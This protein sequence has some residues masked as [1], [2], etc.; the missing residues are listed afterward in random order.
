LRTV[1]H[2]S[3]LL[4]ALAYTLLNAVKP[5]TIDDTAYHAYAAHIAEKPLDP[6]GFSVYWWYQ[7]EVANEVLAPPL[8]SYWWAP[9]IRLFGDRPFLWKLWLLPVALLFAAALYDLS[10]RLAPGLELPLVAMTLFSPAF[11]PTF[12]LMLDVPALAVALASLALFCR[13]C[14]RD[15]FV[16]AAL[17]GLVAGLGIETKYTAFLAPAVMLLYALW[18]G[19][20]RLWPAA[21]LVAAQ[22]F[23]AWEFLMALLYDESHF[24]FHL[25]YNMR[26]SEENGWQWGRLLPP[27]V[28]YLGSLAWPAALLA[29]RGFGL[30]RWAL[31]PAAAAGLLAYAGVAWRGGELQ[32]SIGE[33][34]IRVVFEELLFGTLGA[35]V[36]LIAGAAAITLARPAA[37]L[38][39]WRR[40]RTAAAQGL[41]SWREVMIPSRPTRLTAFL[42]SWLALEVVGYVVLTP[43]PAARRVLGVVVV[44]FLLAG[45]LAARTSRAPGTDR[46]VWGIAACSA[47]LGL[48]VYG[49]DFVEARAQQQAVEEARREIQARGG[50]RVWYVGHWGFQYY[51]EREGMRSISAYPADKG[52]IPIPPQSALQKGDWLVLPEWRLSARGRF[53]AG[54][55]QQDYRL[56]PE[57]TQHAF[58]VVIDDPVPLQ[59]IMALYSGS[60]AVV[61]H[62]GPRL[63]VEVRRVTLDHVAQP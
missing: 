10:R 32:G 28:S 36:V 47:V 50:G 46:A 51:A 24:L 53:L 37:V 33:L 35:G 2:A 60:G 43:F 8:L 34:H 57:R 9:A 44:L 17:A 20:L 55:H 18:L 13:A 41:L 14:D 27:L 4:L 48:L 54:V 11:L 19:R 49:V 21:A 26:Y 1:P 22:V 59:T 25:R 40:R 61:H 31:L 63:Q 3:L 62:E 52:P 15:S 58:D 23:L 6:Y 30:R 45:R 16:L 42:L 39:Q 38:S 56:D 7:P 12:N 5:L 29:L